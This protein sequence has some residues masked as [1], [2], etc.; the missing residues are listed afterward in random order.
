MW[1]G[2]WEREERDGTN[3]TKAETEHLKKHKLQFQLMRKFDKKCPPKA[4]N[5]VFPNGIRLFEYKIVK[6]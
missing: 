6:Y 3:E 1:Y 2:G 5:Q 4:G